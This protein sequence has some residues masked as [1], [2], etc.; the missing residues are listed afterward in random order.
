M[1]IQMFEPEECSPSMYLPILCLAFKIKHNLSS[2]CFGD[3]LKLIQI[4]TQC[5]IEEIK[6]AAKCEAHYNHLKHDIRKIFIC[7]D[8]KCDSVL[9]SIGVDGLPTKNQPCGHVHNKLLGHCYV[10]ILPIEPQVKHYL[11]STDLSKW[12]KPNPYDGSTRGDVQSGRTYRELMVPTSAGVRLWSYQLNVDGAICKKSSKFV[13]WPF[14]LIPNESPYR[15]RRS[16]MMLLSLYYGNKKPPRGPFLNDSIRELE[17]LSTTGILFSGLRFL[18]KPLVLTTDTQA[19]PVFLNCIIFSGECGCN[20]CLHTGK[21]IIESRGFKGLSYFS[22]IFFLLLGQSMAK[23]RGHA[24]MYPEPL[25]GQPSFALRT[26]EQHT[27]DLEV[28]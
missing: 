5:S 16:S 10:L 28:Q 3:A 11:E 13:F 4:S 18:A 8:K 2:S 23:G 6:T 21:T 20:F 26:L 12:N 7:M 9:T 25:D 1:F 22:Y 19:R 15:A 17:K 14:M 24:R 27:T